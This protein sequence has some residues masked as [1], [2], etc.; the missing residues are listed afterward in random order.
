MSVTP[1]Q[2]QYGAGLQG[3]GDG[4]VVSLQ[5][6]MQAA[7]PADGPATGQADYFQQI[8]QQL[9]DFLRAH[10]AA[11]NSELDQEITRLSQESQP[12]RTLSLN[13][14]QLIA[15]YASE[16]TDGALDGL[17]VGYVAQNQFLLDWSND[18]F[19]KPDDDENQW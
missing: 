11:S 14:R 6:S 10:P 2:Q 19:K 1:L 18:I 13:Q 12:A 4:D 3:T 16:S 15:G 9:A 5:Q 8:G 17:R 7:M